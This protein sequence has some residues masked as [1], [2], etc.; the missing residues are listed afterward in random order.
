[1]YIIRNSVSNPGPLLM[2]MMEHTAT[3]NFGLKRS[4]YSLMVVWLLLLV[5]AMGRHGFPG[6]FPAKVWHAAAFSC[7]GS[8]RGI[9]ADAY[10]YST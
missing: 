1:M 5:R 8:A 9:F 6:I 10:I 7:N 4:I 3:C 2:S